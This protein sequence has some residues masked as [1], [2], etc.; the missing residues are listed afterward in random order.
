VGVGA[1][2]KG[3]AIDRT[4][5]ALIVSVALVVTPASMLATAWVLTEGLDFA[6]ASAFDLVSAA[7]CCLLALYVIRV[8]ARE[9]AGALRVR[10]DDHRVAL[11]KVELAWSEIETLTAPK[12]GLLELAG[13]GKRVVL[14]TYLYTDRVELLEFIARQTGKR[15]PELT[16]SY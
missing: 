15:V 16:H 11:G 14:R 13:N 12:F 6:A 8:T 5:V 1:S 10:I 9:L 2:G 7:L 4:G 3:F